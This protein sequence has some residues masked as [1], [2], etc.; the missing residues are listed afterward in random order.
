MLVVVL[1]SMFQAACI[2][3]WPLP[4]RSRLTCRTKLATRHLSYGSE[5]LLKASG[6]YCWWVGRP[7]KAF[8]YGYLESCDSSFLAAL[9]KLG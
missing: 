3:P 9:V 2:C 4:S 7:F 8:V 6:Q 5:T 1:L